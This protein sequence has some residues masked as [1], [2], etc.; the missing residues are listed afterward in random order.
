M[1]RLLIVAHAPSPN[2]R[3]LLEAVLEFP[4]V[5]NDLNRAL[6]GY[7]GLRDVATQADLPLLI[8]TLGSSRADFWVREMLAEVIAPLGG[9][10]VLPELVWAYERN[11][12]DGHDNDLF[13]HVLVE[14]VEADK[15]GSESVLSRIAAEEGAPPVEWLLEACRT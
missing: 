12:A 2:T 1:K 5:D 11:R 9:P 15:A 8:E 7:A 14:L 10:A 13:T 6:R 4:D 3:Q